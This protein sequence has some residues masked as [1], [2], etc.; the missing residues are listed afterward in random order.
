MSDKFI[1]ALND[2]ANAIVPVVDG[3]NLS[4]IEFGRLVAN[5]ALRG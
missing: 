5:W 2:M 1:A 4:V 3:T